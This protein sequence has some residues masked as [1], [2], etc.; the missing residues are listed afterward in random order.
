LPELFEPDFFEPE[1]LELPFLLLP[2]LLLFGADTLGRDLLTLPEDLLLLGLETLGGVL[3]RV[4]LR[5]AGFFDG[6][7]VLLLLLEALLL[8][9]FTF[10]FDTR[11]LCDFLA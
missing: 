3:L 1:L 2:V 6:L 11:S 7:Y 4:V 5:T 10:C 9:G 8:L